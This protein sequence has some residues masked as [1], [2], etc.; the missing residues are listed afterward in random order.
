MYFYTVKQTILQC[1]AEGNVLHEQR[2]NIDVKNLLATGQVSTSE[3]SCLVARSKGTEYEC[4]PHHILR[5]IDVHILKTRYR[6]HECY[7]KWYF[8]EPN[9]VFI[10]VHLS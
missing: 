7:I 8:V 10:S 6:N 9:C 5:E 2:N 4:K 1:L 3:I